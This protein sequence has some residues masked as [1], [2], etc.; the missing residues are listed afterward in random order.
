MKPMHPKK[1]FRKP[2]SGRPMRPVAGETLSRP[3]HAINEETFG[4]KQSWLAV[5]RETTETGGP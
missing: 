2:F 5:G 4:T 1:S 3:L